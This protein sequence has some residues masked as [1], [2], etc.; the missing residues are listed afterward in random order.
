M[1][2]KHKRL[3]KVLNRFDEAINAAVKEIIDELKTN[4]ETYKEVDK[5]L[6]LFKK[7]I[8]FNQQNRQKYEY[9]L[10][11]VREVI[12]EEKNDLPLTNRS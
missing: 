4:T 12:E 10:N 1:E 5:D 7:A 3:E 2:S 9:L 6:K 8:E 11:R